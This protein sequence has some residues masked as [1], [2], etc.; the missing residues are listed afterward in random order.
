M[1]HIKRANKMW[2]SDSLFLRPTLNI[3]IM[4][5]DTSPLYTPGSSV[6]STPTAANGHS[7]ANSADFGKAEAGSSSNKS[8]LDCDEISLN[9]PSAGVSR[10][11][12][13]ITDAPTTSDESVADFLMRIDSSISKT[14]SQVTQVEGKLSEIDSDFMRFNNG[15]SSGRLSNS[16]RK[17]HNGSA[18]SLTSNGSSE[19]GHTT[20]ITQGRKVK[21]SLRRLAKQQDELFQL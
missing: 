16:H 9:S 18:T 20:V 1:E 2:T 12:S 13:V 11:N 3:P 5:S 14:K 4:G 6:A 15:R 10:Q 19:L 7:L 21:T 8:S 17:N